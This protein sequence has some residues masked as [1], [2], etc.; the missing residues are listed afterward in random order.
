MQ[1]NNRHVPNIRA[2]VRGPAADSGAAPIAEVILADLIIILGV[3]GVGGV[4]IPKSSSS[5]DQLGPN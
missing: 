1:E 3:T 4:Q 5:F 2:A